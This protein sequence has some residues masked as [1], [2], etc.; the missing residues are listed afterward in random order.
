MQDL[1]RGGTL[2]VPA[3]GALRPHSHVLLQPFGPRLAGVDVPVAIDRDELRAVSGGLPWI[4]PRIHDE[5][6][7]P[8]ALRVADPDAL[9]P[10]RVLHIVGLRVG[11][12]DLIL[13]VE[14]DATRL[15]ELGPGRR[16]RFPV[17]VEDLDPIVAAVAD[18]DAP[19]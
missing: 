7:H 6:V 3:R 9:L 14:R 2:A 16:Q 13:T 11:D 18:E 15:A 1:G 4:A 17:L 10:S 5:G 19:P 8:S 12:V